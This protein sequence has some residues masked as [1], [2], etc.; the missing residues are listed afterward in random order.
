MTSQAEVQRSL[1][2]ID[3]PMGKKDLIQHAR[4]AKASESVMD[5]LSHLPDRQYSKPTD[6]EKEIGNFSH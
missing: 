5:T 1:K 3:Y 4:S 2:G 6:V